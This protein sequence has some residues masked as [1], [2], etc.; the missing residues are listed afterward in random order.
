MRKADLVEAILADQPICACGQRAEWEVIVDY[1][2]MRA[3]VCHRHLA[4]SITFGFLGCRLLAY[5]W[6]FI[7]F[8][9]DC[10]PGDLPR[11]VMFFKRFVNKWRHDR[12]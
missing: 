8:N 12:A 4:R 11:Q 7:P 2:R 1:D 5:P 9:D 10:S 3:N 6:Q